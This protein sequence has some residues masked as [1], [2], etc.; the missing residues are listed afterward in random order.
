MTLKLRTLS[1]GLLLL[2]PIAS[3]AKEKTYTDAAIKA[4]YV[5]NI[6]HYITWPEKN[7][8]LELCIVGDD[9]VGLSLVSELNKEEASTNINISKHDAA[10]SLGE[11]NIVY[12]SASQVSKLSTILYKIESLPVLTISDIGSFA[13]KGGMIEFAIVEHKVKLLIN[14]KAARSHN[15]N[16]S[17]KLLNFAAQVQE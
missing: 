12:I 1:L 6:R 16:I 14:I 9:L 17:S 2:L 15:I 13:K 3:K 10:G 7:N 4:A 5:L 11:C 8:P